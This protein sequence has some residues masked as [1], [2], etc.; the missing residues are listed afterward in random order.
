MADQLELKIA[1]SSHKPE[2]HGLTD[3]Q[4]DDVRD[5][6]E[7]IYTVNKWRIVRINFLRGLAFGLGTF[8]G[9]TIV[10]AI[11]V[12]ILSQTID[13][14]PPVRDFVERIIQSLQK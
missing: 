3:K 4:R 13:I 2:R 9:G 5:I 1:D 8:L 10:V 14:F 11:L 7:N 12:W 6:F